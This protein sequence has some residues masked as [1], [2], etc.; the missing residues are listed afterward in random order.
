MPLLKEDRY[1]M[2]CHEKPIPVP[3]NDCN[4]YYLLVEM[5]NSDFQ[6][7]DLGYYPEVSS[8][9]FGDEVQSEQV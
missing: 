6:Y 1:N 4:S 8:I 7:G 5:A 9:Y 3:Q 2:T